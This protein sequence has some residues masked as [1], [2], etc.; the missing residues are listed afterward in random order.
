MRTL[1]QS[2]SSCLTISTS[3][4]LRASSSSSSRLTFMASDMDHLHLS[5]YELKCTAGG[6][7]RPAAGRA[8]DRRV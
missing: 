6:H 3:S 1:S 4:P 5:W 2:P 8:A 7:L